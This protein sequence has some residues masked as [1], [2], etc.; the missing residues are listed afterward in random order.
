[1]TEEELLTLAEELRPYTEKAMKIEPAP[2]IKDYLVDMEELYTELTLEKV[3]EKLF[4]EDRRKL[5]NYKDLFAWQKQGMLE[6]LDIRYYHPKLIP[7]MKILFKGNPGMGKTSLVKKI[8]YDWA[9]GIF[10]NVSIVFF[11]F[12]KS[13]KQDEA[14][15]SVIIRQTPALQGLHVT[16]EKI[17]S[18]LETFGNQCLIIF[19][20]LDECAFGQNED[21]LKI[22][23]G[24]KWLLTNVVVTS[25]PHSAKQIERYC[26][27][28]ISVEGFT[29]NEAKKFTSRIVLNEEKV[30]QILDFNPN[31]VNEK[32]FSGENEKQNLHNIPILLSFLCVLV[33]E[34]G[35]DLSDKSIS[36]GDIYFRMVKCLYK[37]YTIRNGLKFSMTTLFEVLKS[38]GKLALETLFKSPFFQRSQVIEE[39]GSE[40][41]DYGLLI[42]QE[43]FRL[44]RDETADIL[45]TFPHRS[46]Q[47]FL[48]AF[49]FVLA[50]II[51]TDLQNFSSAV[52]AFMTNPLFHEFC[53]WWLDCSKFA[54][55]CPSWNA[56]NA[57]KVHR[58]LVNHVT[59]H[60]NRAKIDLIDIAKRFPAFD[61]DLKDE[62]Q[63]S[64]VLRKVLGKC[65]KLR[66]LRTGFQHS[67]GQILSSLGPLFKFLR[68][69]EVHDNNI[70]DLKLEKEI[71]T[72][73]DRMYNCQINSDNR[74][75][76]RSDNDLIIDVDRMSSLKDIYKECKKW[77]R[78]P[79]TYINLS[80]ETHGKFELAI[81]LNETVKE[82]CLFDSRKVV[83]NQEIP[84]CPRL[85][86]LSLCNLD[87]E[88]VAGGLSEAFRNSKFPQLTHL[89]LAHRRIG[90]E[91]SLSSLSQSKCSTVKH[92]DL[93]GFD[94]V[95]QD[96][97]F[98]HSVH[99]DTDN[100]VLP[101]LSSLVLDSRTLELEPELY[102]LFQNPWNKL[103]EIRFENN[104]RGRFYELFDFMNLFFSIINDSKL[105]NLATLHLE[106]IE[107]DLNSLHERKVPHLR[108]LTLH[109]SE[110][111]P[112][113]FM[114]ET[115][116]SERLLGSL[117]QKLSTWKLEKLDIRHNR[118]VGG[119]L[120]IL[121]SNTLR[122]LKSLSVTHCGLNKDDLRSLGVA[123]EKGRLPK[124]T[125]L[126]VSDN[127]MIE[128]IPSLFH[129]KFRSLQ[130]LNVRNCDLNEDDLLAINRA[131]AVGK[132]PKLKYLDISDNFFDQNISLLFRVDRV[133]F[134][135]LQ[136]LIVKNCSLCDDELRALARVN[137]EGKLPELKHLD[138]SGNGLE[139]C[140]KLLTRDP[141]TSKLGWK[142]V[143]CDDEYLCDDVPTTNTPA[144]AAPTL[145]LT[146]LFQMLRKNFSS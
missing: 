118:A 10:I 135:S 11:V 32:D 109:M 97:H 69:I 128:P 117:V 114:F 53:L 112:R 59:D 127:P 79:C 33:R 105:P 81:I 16:K 46:L 65:D 22:V 134:R 55:I 137:A 2:W 123:N 48:G 144:H 80:D 88:Q 51:E 126:D 140:S 28:I 45:I 3:D 72:A 141:E 121:E 64:S 73:L 63:K 27:T 136:V 62:T 37:K 102:I 43:D 44:I 41:F 125:Y 92:L 96:F 75:N 50:L 20:G 26:D 9:N 101:N 12:L 132:L 110:I 76:S 8:A 56:W 85:T 139:Y 99:T 142:S 57:Q 133:E 116:Q 47:E 78:I 113:Q 21:V 14:I 19:D 54:E 60:I 90:R 91:V 7:K 103:T 83:C 87:F 86:H 120:H 29:R 31:G 115:R 36:V 145:S 93:S 74:M 52:K 71:K 40:V 131:N 4:R 15:E 38:L 34:D 25:R 67:T 82:L 143:K 89:S 1:M 100:S 124:L 77:E 119:T 98:L 66:H 68:S 58:L 13:V 106:G 94:L 61:A 104:F 49:Y 23:E 70:R 111:E 17:A 146:N 18:I 122:S 30:Q 35:I 5:E 42:G 84:C 130:V 108:S 138:I 39:V 107:T 95:E 129:K 24:A 6:Y